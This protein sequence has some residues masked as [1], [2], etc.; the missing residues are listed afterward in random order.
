MAATLNSS[1]DANSNPKEDTVE[2]D[3]N[4]NDIT[5]KIVFN[6]KKLDITWDKTKTISSLKSYIHPLTEVPPAMQ[7]LMFKGLLKDGQ[8]LSE[9][10]I[11]TGTK[12]MLVGSKLTDVIT[13]NT[14]AESSSTSDAD[15]GSSSKKEP[16][17]KQKPHTKV[18]EQGVPED[19]MPAYKNG[20]EPL[21]DIP[22]FGM[23]NKNR[24]KVRLTFKL[25][26]DQL[27]LGTK[28][29][30]EKLPMNSIKQIVSEAIEGH[31]EYHMMALQLGPTEQSR[32]WIYWVPS[33]Y[34]DAIKDVVLGTWGQF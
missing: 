19:A 23:L 30:T 17:S 3:D 6:K 16:L 33:Q 11:T 25:A 15:S 14:K 21:P 1:G 8:T 32:Y 34:I 24:H 27:W 9:A 20:K 13:A 31:E 18:I 22:L 29:R 5:F 26:E 12:V 7:K 10:K 4:P 2:K 28:E